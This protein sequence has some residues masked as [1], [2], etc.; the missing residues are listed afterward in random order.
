M[1]TITATVP[2][3]RPPS[4]AL[5][6]RR[7]IAAMN[8]A[9]HPFVET[10]V[11]PNGELIWDDAFGG[12]SP[13]DFYETYFN[14]P[15]LY[16]MGGGEHLMEL[17]HQGWEG[18]TRLLTRCGTVYKE[19]ALAEDQ[20]HQ[21]ESDIFFYHLC[22]A[23]PRNGSL[24]MRARRFAGLYLNEDLDAVNYD[25]EHKIILS[26][27]NG[28]GG[29]DYLSDD[30]PTKGM[31]AGE[32]YGLPAYDVPGIESVSDLDDEEKALRLAAVMQK[33]YKK[34]DV[35]ANLAVTSLV[36]NAF[37]ISGEE[38]YRDW[39]LEYTDAWMERARR[40]DGLLPD[41][42]GHSGQVGEYIDGKWYGGVYGWTAW[43]GWYNLQMTATDVAANAYLLT[44]DDSYLELPRR[45]MDRILEMGEQRDIHGEHM[46]LREHWMGQFTA[47]RNRTETLCVP[48]RYGDAGWFDWQPPSPTFLAALW[49]LSMAD[50]DWER[51]ERVRQAEAYDW[52]EVVSFHNKEDSCHDQ[53]WLR[54]LAGANPDYPEAMLQAAYQ[55]VVQRLGV[56]REETEAGTHRNVHRWQNANPVTTEALIQQTLG[57][58][59]PIYNGGLLHA[60]LRYYDNIAKCPGLP[61]DVG[62]LVEKL[63]A[64]RTVVRLVNLN[65][66]E[67][68]EL[69]VQAGAFG[70]HSFDRVE[71]SSLT[72]VF[73]GTAVPYAA[74]PVTSAPRTVRVGGKHLTVELPPATEITLDL[75][76]QRYVNEP[77]LRSGPF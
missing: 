54:F 68:R 44:R 36:T 24:V 43:H 5:H 6:Q 46:S 3:E 67:V 74:D 1:E 32:R 8:D 69:V 30:P 34:G 48:Y 40:N 75:S 11:H 47:M 66:V 38:K 72:S 19:Y 37:L 51:I 65:P 49:N 20:F 45:Q 4:W 14:W 42:V 73:P 23:D 70:E 33:R 71:Y 17:A 16:L 26:P 41:N 59:Q 29:P 57:G 62:A 21:S 52:N 58:P 18:V 22:L 9:V 77:S 39:V 35:A 53:P 76:T 31:G 25:P 60:R 56:V 64:Q 7:L 15:L 27:R 2:I 28:S 13:D 10:Y 12:G 63:E 61:S 55:S 50:E